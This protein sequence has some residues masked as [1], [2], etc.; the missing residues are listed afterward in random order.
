[1][2]MTFDKN[3]YIIIGSGSQYRPNEVYVHERANDNGKPGKIVT[4]AD[5]KGDVKEIA[6]QYIEQGFDPKK[7]IINGQPAED[8]F[9]HEKE[10]TTQKKSYELG[11]YKPVY[12]NPYDL[13]S[14]FYHPTT[15]PTT[16]ACNLNIMNPAN[17]LNM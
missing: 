4:M 2:Y 13:N 15:D 6:K 3:N 12:N 17:N 9:V 11:T 7:I 10:K 8:I 1:M 5:G 14:P 16:P